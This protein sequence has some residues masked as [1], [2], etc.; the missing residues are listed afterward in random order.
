MKNFKRVTFALLIAA[1][2]TVFSP[3]YAQDYYFQVPSMYADVYINEDGTASIEYLITFQ[4][5]PGAHIIDY[6]DIGMPNSNFEW[7]SITATIDGQPITDIESSPYVK[8][9]FALGLGSNSIPAGSSG[10]VYV[11]VDVVRDM[12]FLASAQ[13]E[14]PYASFNFAPVWFDKDYTTG[15]TD[16]TVTL[17]MP[18]G[19]TDEEP[20][21]I[22]PKKFPGDDE[23]LAG[24]DEEG[25][26]V[27]QW[28]SPDANPYT[29]YTFGATLPARY[30][31]ETTVSE[32]M[33]VTFD[34]GSIFDALLPICCFGGF[35]GLFILIIVVAIKS[36][37]KRK[38]KYLPPKISV[39]GLG[40]KRGLTPIEVGIL[41]EQ[42]MDKILTMILFATMQKEAAEI[43]KR[44]P[45]EVKVEEKLPEDLRPYEKEFLEAFRLKDKRARTR[46]LQNMMVTLVKSVSEKMKGF[47]R[48]ETL[49]FYKDIMEK[50]WK[51]VEDADTPEVKGERYQEQM[52]WTMLDNDYDQR[53]RRVFG[54][55]PVFMPWWWWRAD[56]TMSR[57]TRSATST[58]ASATKAAGGKAPSAGSRTTTVRI[59]RLAG[60]NAAAS[61]V[62][63][64]QAFS[65]GVVGNL[66]NFTDRITNKTNPLPK[67]SSSGKSFR[68]SSGGGRPSCVCAC[69]CA[70]A[71]CACA[72]AGGGR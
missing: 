28:T 65:A 26:I 14:E 18:P 57:T 20:R 17:H 6:V 45:L 23:P 38:L 50:A 63:T 21:Y 22:T 41:M 9:G 43:I 67:S 64:V 53:T 11:R 25:R 69:A 66:T 37:K 35:F 40:I 30:V 42:P 39:E 44:E 52:S 60:S 4:N 47:S 24:Y 51:Q 3:V 34:S 48:K 19:L 27:Y 32:D 36:S 5:E 12:L 62:G 33:V 2:L 10:T 1:L 16:L 55:G 54:T 8:Y 15:S 31:P 7:S 72:C 70:C 61:V 49:A 68:S 13:E 71:G 59:P 29:Q 58:V 46:A 56:P